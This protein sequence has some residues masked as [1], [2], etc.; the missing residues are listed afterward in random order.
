MADLQVTFGAQIGELVTGFNAVKAQLEDLKSQFDSVKSHTEDVANNTKKMSDGFKQLRDTLVAVFSIDAIS[1]FV[2]SM[3]TMGSKL[4]S[5]SFGMGASMQSVVELAGIAKITGTTID[6]LSG[7]IE[8]MALNIQR[9]TKDSTNPFAQALK[10]LGLSAKDFIGLNGPE[11]FE[12]LAGAVSKFNPSMNLTTNLMQLGGRS[13]REMIPALMQGEEA[14]HKYRQAIQDATQGLA[15]AAP[16]MADTHS[17]LALLSLAVEALRARIFTALKPAIDAII[18]AFTKWAKSIDSSTITSAAQAVGNAMISIMETLSGFIL[19]VLELID[20]LKRSLGDLDQFA[21]NFRGDIMG[22]AVTK[23]RGQMA[24]QWELWNLETAAAIGTITETGRKK[25]QEFYDAADKEAKEGNERLEK[26]RADFK[27]VV[28]GFRS[29]ITGITN[30]L[31]APGQTAANQ[32]P[33]GGGQ[34]A[35]A[36]KFTGGGGEELAAAQRQIAQI[37]QLYQMEVEKINHAF[38]M[39]A[40]F[41][42]QA[43]QQKTSSLLSAI[44]Q[45]LSAELAV[46]DAVQAKYAA[47]SKEYQR[48]EDEKTKIIQKAALERLRIENQAAEDSWNKWK[49]ASS[50]ISSAFNSHLRDMFTGTMTFGQAVGRTL[51]DL[52]IKWTGDLT[53]MAF[54]WVAKQLFMSVTGKTIMAGDVAAHGVAETAKTASTTAGVA[55]RTSAEATGAGANL[56]TWIADAFKFIFVQ[57]QKV[58]AGVFAFLSPAMGPAAAGPAE[59]SSVAVMASAAVL[60]VGT[61]YV[62]S[63][64]LALIHEGEAV[65]PAQTNGAFRDGSLGG[66]TNHYHNYE[67]DTYEI[68]AIDA[69][70]FATFLNRAG[71]TQMMAKKISRKQ[72]L[73]PST[74]GKF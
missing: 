11:Y 21:D 19:E 72:N 26:R 60:A 5:I 65:I 42:G 29:A 45:R 49:S 38:K 51:G 73:N 34:N 71:N 58:F 67:G 69:A 16:G 7:G 53:K 4:E 46:L 12:K 20:K 33:P 37:D 35:P 54:E 13:F 56:F 44:Q 2:E 15:A 59:A 57:A 28:D 40:D 9:A 24:Q 70:S 32:P 43:E 22:K 14:F 63:T 3:A 61:N 23:V 55:A 39:S 48:I 62:S 74:R 6:Q 50:D 41:F 18:E 27:A 17:K 8:R 31:G 47:G 30:T 68:K 10:N 1:T 52:I 25:L 66:D 64:G 36:L